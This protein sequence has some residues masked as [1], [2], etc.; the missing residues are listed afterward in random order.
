[1]D[2]NK[3]LGIECYHCHKKGHIQHHCPDKPVVAAFGRL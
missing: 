1:V 3:Y 2:P